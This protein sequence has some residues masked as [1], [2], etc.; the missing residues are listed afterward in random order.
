MAG[1]WTTKEFES[2]VREIESRKDKEPVMKI[3]EELA[4]N[5]QFGRRTAS[6]LISKY[7]RWLNGHEG[8]DISLDGDSKSGDSKSGGIKREADIEYSLGNEDLD[9]LLSDIPA[10]EEEKGYTTPVL[11]RGERVERV[12]N[13]PAKRNNA[14]AITENAVLLAQKMIEMSYNPEVIQAFE[15]LPEYIRTLENEIAE[16][17]RNK[18]HFN[19]FSFAKEMWEMA[20]RMEQVGQVEEKIA[21]QEKRIQELEE[22]IKDRE[23][24][25]ESMKQDYKDA[26]E[27]FNVFMNRSSV[28]Q[29]MAM[30]DVKQ[31]MKTTLDKWGNVLRVEF[32]GEEFPY[33][34]D[35]EERYI[36]R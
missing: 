22:R 33:V 16:L 7:Y 23:E 31:R 18:G 25:I 15:G 4:D 9:A 12:D 19:F 8:E 36:R 35:P 3:C 34:D 26:C 10:L 14:I 21:G 30:G 29:M 13:T 2:L 1:A 5:R 6:A 20:Q 27:W 24:K 11:K 32:E 17:K 28:Q